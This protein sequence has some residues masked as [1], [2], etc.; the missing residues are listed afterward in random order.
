[1]NEKTIWVIFAA[2]IILV[3]GWQPITSTILQFYTIYTESGPQIVD[4][5]K[6]ICNL[7][8]IVTDQLIDVVEKNAKDNEKIQQII[9]TYRKTGTITQC[10]VKQL[11]S[12]LDSEQKKK[13]N[14]SEIVCNALNCAT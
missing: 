4:S 8:N 10:D 6:T 9:D 1:M 3:F 13:L 11:I 14:V 7:E 2:I 12:M 5:A